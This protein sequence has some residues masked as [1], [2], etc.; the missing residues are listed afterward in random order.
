VLFILTRQTVLCVCYNPFR[1]IWV[2]CDLRPLTVTRLCS[3]TSSV[4]TKVCLL[5]P[6]SLLARVWPLTHPSPFLAVMCQLTG[7]C[8]NC[9][10]LL[11]WRALADFSPPTPL[12]RAIASTPQT[13]VKVRPL[14]SVLVDTRFSGS[15]LSC[16]PTSSAASA[17]SASRFVWLLG[18]Y[19]CFPAP[20]SGDSCLT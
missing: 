2:A 12:Q 6:P 8:D 5:R 18:A 16:R 7:R 19:P 14:P 11:P 10:C 3:T 13:A 15:P 4:P 1:S 9:R 20:S 17:G